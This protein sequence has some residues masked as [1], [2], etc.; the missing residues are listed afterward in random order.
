MR[1]VLNDQADQLQD[2]AS[3]VVTLPC[4]SRC[5]TADPRAGGSATVSQSAA[6]TPHQAEGERA[7]MAP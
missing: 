4:R 2:D 1:S 3:V 6:R 5:W 7:T